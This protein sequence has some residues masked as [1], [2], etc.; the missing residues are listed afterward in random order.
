MS[1]KKFLAIIFVLTVTL[2]SFCPAIPATSPVPQSTSPSSWWYQRFLEKSAYLK[3]HGANILL[4]GDSITE[5]WEVTTRGKPILAAYLQGSPYYCYV[6]GYSADKTEN[7]LWRLE[8]GELTG[9]EP[10][11]VVLTIGTN[12]TWLRTE[13]QEPPCDTVLGIRSIV[14]LIQQRAPNTV[15]ILNAIPPIGR[16]G[17][18]ERRARNTIVNDA[19]KRMADG[20]KIRWCEINSQLMTPE[21]YYGEDVSYD[22]VHPTTA[23]YRLWAKNLTPFFNDI[24]FPDE[25]PDL[26]KPV[27]KMGEPWWLERFTDI[28]CKSLSKRPEIVF[29]GD[30]L[31]EGYVAFSNE[32]TKTFLDAGIAGD[33]LQQLNWRAKYGSLSTYRSNYVVLHAGLIDT[34]C[35]A[36]EFVEAF[37]AI[38]IQTRA[39]QPYAKIFIMAV[40]PRGELPTDPE[41]IRI[42]AINKGL[43]EL[44]DGQVSFFVDCNDKL[45]NAD[46][47]LSRE[48]SP[49]FIHFS[50]PAY[51]IWVE[52]LK[53]L[54]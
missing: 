35:T 23:G 5:L 15:I 24:L 19:I 27:A 50:K 34:H 18:D 29:F 6:V 25:T 42:A 1:T 9:Y 8:N 21:G 45:L 48:I 37:K 4:V 31:T 33:S 3:E 44:Q 12:N 41:R 20:D 38:Y 36:D 28:R 39:K 10:R 52:A 46:G 26:L 16:T 13:N 17:D 47:T 43:A 7:V 2:S 49:D 32:F 54:L 22:G 51:E 30:E 11:I 14:S 40:P 53:A